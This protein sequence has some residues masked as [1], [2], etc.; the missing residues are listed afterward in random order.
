MTSARLDAKA[1]FML[2]L[3]AFV[4]WL[5]CGLTMGLGRSAFGLETAL[6]VHAVAAPIFA[7]LVS[8][9]YFERF[10]AVSPLVAAA[11]VTVIIVVLDAGLVAPVFE[12][13]AMHLTQVQSMGGG[14]H[15][16]RLP[17]RSSFAGTGLRS[18]ACCMSRG[19]SRPR[20][21]DVRRLKRKVYSSR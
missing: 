18:T 17:P 5:A 12:N 1:V 6:K 8:L 15:W 11:F 13:V 10:R 2:S 9:V 4:V 20:D 16:N 7:A 3:S 21:P 19:N 14:D